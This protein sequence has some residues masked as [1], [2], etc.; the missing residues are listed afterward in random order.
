LSIRVA[1]IKQSCSAK[2]KYTFEEK[3]LRREIKGYEK[4]RSSLMASNV[5]TT[6]AA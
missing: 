1:E 6:I 5:N 2:G 4:Y 3:L